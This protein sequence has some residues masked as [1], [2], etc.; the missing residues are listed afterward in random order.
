MEN[1][2]SY[3]ILLLVVVL[4]GHSVVLCD[5]HHGGYTICYIW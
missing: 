5:V 4:S 2:P 1:T 3:A